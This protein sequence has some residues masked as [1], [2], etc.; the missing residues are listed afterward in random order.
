MLTSYANTGE[1]VE[2][3]VTMVVDEATM[4][5][6]ETTVNSSPHQE[7]VVEGLDTLET[8]AA[9]DHEDGG[10]DEVPE[11]EPDSLF[12]DR[13]KEMTCP[14]E[15]IQCPDRLK[16]SLHHNQMPHLNSTVLQIIKKGVYLHTPFHNT[17]GH[18]HQRAKKEDNEN[19]HP[20]MELQLSKYA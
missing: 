18:L 17:M 14:P 15:D 6:M 3:E 20:L 11:G 1:E 4:E 13:F 7:V 12:W 2:V 10:E 19:L 16:W 9:A 5:I 8:G